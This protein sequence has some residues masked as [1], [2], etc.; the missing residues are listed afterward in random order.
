MTTKNIIQIA[1]RY[2]FA[3]H[4]YSISGNSYQEGMC[5]AFSYVRDR[6]EA[7]EVEQFDREFETKLKKLVAAHQKKYPNPND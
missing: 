3:A 6:L 1:Q 2:A 4:N 7:T 5:S